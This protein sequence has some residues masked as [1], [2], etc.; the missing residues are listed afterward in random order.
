MDIPYGVVGPHEYGVKNRI[1]THDFVSRTHLDIFPSYYPEILS[2]WWM[3]DWIS[4]VYG[5]NRTFLMSSVQVKHHVY[6]HDRR[7]QVN[8]THLTYLPQALKDG[9]KSLRSYIISSF[10]HKNISDLELKNR[11]Q[12]FLLTPDDLVA[13]PDHPKLTKITR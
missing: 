3:D 5:P 10:R 1:L 13:F 9:K 7:Y 6:N 12:E 4:R 8:T 2:D 11:V